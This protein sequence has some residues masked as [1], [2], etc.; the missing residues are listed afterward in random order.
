MKLPDLKTEDAF[1][2]VQVRYYSSIW[3]EEE[4]ILEQYFPNFLFADP[5]WRHK[6]TTN[7]PS[8]FT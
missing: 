2:V 8:L 1:P 7:L 6:M 3:F 5:F 4:I